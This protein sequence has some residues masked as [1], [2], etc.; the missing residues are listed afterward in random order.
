MIKS[1]YKNLRNEVQQDQGR[2]S[3]FDNT[4]KRKLTA[5]SEWLSS[6]ED[7]ASDTNYKKY[8][9][10]SPTN[11]GLFIVQL[12]GETLKYDVIEWNPKKPWS[13]NRIVA[14]ANLP[15]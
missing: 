8:P 11:C 13:A 3:A 14:W 1:D 4:R 10:E 9:K 12:A 6:K 7:V 2:L 15:E 5:I